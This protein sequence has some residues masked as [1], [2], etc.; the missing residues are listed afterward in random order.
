MISGITLTVTE[1][2]GPKPIAGVTLM[3]AVPSAIPVIV[4]CCETLAT[5]SSV[6]FQIM[7]RSSSSSGASIAKTIVESMPMASGRFSLTLNV[8]PLI[9]LASGMA[10]VN[11]WS[12]SHAV[13]VMQAASIPMDARLKPWYIEFLFFMLLSS[14][15]EWK[16]LIYSPQPGF[17]F[18]FGFNC[19]WSVGN[20]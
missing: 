18:R 10:G 19:N 7:E 3:I 12:L 2:D 4:P 14:F 5:V 11:S 8:M 20:G 13:R 15:Y 9:S 1:A 17:C 6:D 16:T